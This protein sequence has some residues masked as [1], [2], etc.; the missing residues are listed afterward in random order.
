MEYKWTENNSKLLIDFYGKYRD[1][2][3]TLQMRSLKALWEKIAEELRK[4]NVHVTPNNCLNRWRVLDRNYKKFID[5]NNKT[6]KFICKNKL[7]HVQYR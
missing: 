4:L 6:G 2:V 1:K 7:V 3:G 5:N